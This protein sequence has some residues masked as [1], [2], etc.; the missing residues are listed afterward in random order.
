MNLLK[1]QSSG[2]A[3]SGGRTKGWW[4]GSWGQSGGSSPCKANFLGGTESS[5]SAVSYRRVINILTWKKYVYISSDWLVLAVRPGLLEAPP[6]WSGRRCVES[7]GGLPG[8]GSMAGVLL[9]FVFFVF[10]IKKQIFAKNLRPM[11]TF[12]LGQAFWGC[13]GRPVEL[14]NVVWLTENQGWGRII[15]TLM[16][17]S[18]SFPSPAPTLF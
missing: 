15:P 9:L 8:E 12:V 1:R 3:E 16:N 18:F 14:S 11:W 6:A 4:W 13:L 5:K 10:W 2:T 17:N 7:W